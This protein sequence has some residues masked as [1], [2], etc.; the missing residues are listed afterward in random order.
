MSV[1]WFKA[2]WLLS[3]A[4]VSLSVGAR[5]EKKTEREKERN[6]QAG[7]G[8]KES[9]ASESSACCLFFAPTAAAAFKLVPQL[10]QEKVVAIFH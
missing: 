8:I 5:V 10:A 2:W 6:G 9:S 3:S 4:C 7:A 1:L